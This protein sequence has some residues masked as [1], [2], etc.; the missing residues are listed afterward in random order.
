MFFEKRAGG[1]V[2]VKAFC[3]KSK[4][5]VS[6][7]YTMVSLVFELLTKMSCDPSELKDDGS[8]PDK[9]LLLKLNK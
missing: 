6:L 7:S 3:D 8:V 2:P 5:T 4:I 9:A 1:M